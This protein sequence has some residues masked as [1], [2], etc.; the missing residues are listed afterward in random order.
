MDVPVSEDRINDAPPF[1]EPSEGP[2]AAD[3]ANGRVS[4]DVSAV[5]AT[6]YSRGDP[7]SDPSVATGTHRRASATAGDIPRDRGAR[8]STVEPREVSGFVSVPP[9]PPANN[10]AAPRFEGIV[11]C[12][13]LFVD[14][15]VVDQSD[16]YGED[17][18]EIEAPL[19]ELS[20]K[21][22]ETRV[23][24]SDPQTRFFTFDGGAA[25]TR[26]RDFA[27]ES[28]VRQV[29]EGFGALDL[30]CLDSHGVAPGVEA[31]YLVRIDGDVHSYCAFTAYVIP[32]LRAMGFEVTVE[33]TYPYKTVADEMPW[34]AEVNVEEE[35]PN[36]FNLEL[37]VE[38]DGRRINLLP[39]LL[40]VLDGMSGQLNLQTLMSRH[41]R[42]FALPVDDGRYLTLPPERIRPLL[43]VL[44]ELYQ[45]PSASR[46]VVAFQAHNAGVLVQLEDSF[47]DTAKGLH[48]RDNA[49]ART[50]GHALHGD[51]DTPVA[52]PPGLHA[53]LR[54][55][56]AEG[57]TW[58]Q[59]LRKMGVGGILA[60]DMGLG[61]TLQT[62]AHLLLEHGG[63]AAKG[64]SMVV[65]PT[66][67]MGNW[68]RE[69]AKFAPS[70]RVLVYVGPKRA[71]LRSQ[72]EDVDVVVTSYPI[73]LRD[74]EYL[75]ALPIHLLI[76]DEAQAIKNMR[77]QVHQAVRG[78]DP[79]HRL[80]LTGTPV[81]NHLGELWALMDFLNPGLLG[82]ELGFRRS[83]RIPIERQ[84]DEERLKAL[85]HQLAPFILRR[86][87]SEV[88]KELPPKTELMFPVELSGRQ[89]DL[90]ESIRV[91]AH[92]RVRSVI[93]KKGFA[94][95]TVSILDALM[96]LR[97]VC[98]DPRLLRMESA[99]AVEESAKHEALFELVEKQLNEGHRILIFS[100]FTR[101][102]ALVSQGLRHAGVE[103]LMLTGSTVNRQA[104]I[105]DFE[106][107]KADVFL[108]S[109]KA[110]G[111]G[112]TLT[113]ADTVIHYDPWWNPAAQAQAT[114]R[115][116]RI[117]QKRP[118]FVY[119]LFVAGSVEERMLGLQRRKRKLANA[120]LGAARPEAFSEDDLDALFAPL[121]V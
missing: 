35:R 12:V 20:F 46:S 89:R 7:T 8:Q 94:A 53:T 70:L 109:L 38:F 36:W 2:R 49:N 117:G 91:A 98:C 67:L 17:L 120:I 100:Q 99:R 11:P 43:H 74:L 71:R 87:K 69:I 66:S 61:K 41:R 104:V 4:G 84:G 90:Y 25:V 63:G 103:H 3:A 105:D 39:A 19:I 28:R 76:L 112:L 55:Y 106:G 108:I 95:S 111:T 18:E 27:A 115:A 24:A 21:Y 72:L 59:R 47:A 75:E 6:G 45:G 64:P 14:A 82:D 56:Q 10:V 101:M 116:Y 16:G 88:A 73:L 5:G 32:Q 121:S 110:G 62:I 68:Q 92:D 93:R 13:R 52:P 57:L 97:L 96:K 81:E 40:D 33:E 79:E 83:F 23:Q 60:D 114:D 65:A 9:T 54:P 85:Q 30:Q 22:P 107:G 102:L 34:Y 80:C 58:L 29:L 118:V 86:T 26:E 37:G 48:W 1:S 31:D 119:N 15:V 44:V 51:L 50:L 42:C 78:L 77:S 113:S